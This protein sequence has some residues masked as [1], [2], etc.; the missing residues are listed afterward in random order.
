MRYRVDLRVTVGNDSVKTNLVKVGGLELQHLVDTTTVDLVGSIANLLGSTLTT[1]ETG[2]NEL[3]TVLVE[4]VEGVE[5]GT[6][7]DLDQLCETVTDLSIGKTAEEGEVKEGVHGS[8][9]G[10]KTVLVV[11]VVDANL[12]RDGSVN[13]TNDGGGNTDEV[14]V[15]AVRSAGETV[16]G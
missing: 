15:S 10:T 1:T 5:V 7:G 11:I 12:D 2:L 8:V 9:V 16:N 14:G 3:L 13:E 4:Q 6:G